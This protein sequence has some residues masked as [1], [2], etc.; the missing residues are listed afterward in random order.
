MIKKISFIL[1][2][3]ISSFSIVLADE[4]DFDFV[5]GFS[6]IVTDEY[7]KNFDKNISKIN[8]Q[9]QA[10]GK[11][12]FNINYCYVSFENR[13]VCN[14]L[15]DLSNPII[16]FSGLGTHYI[17]FNSNF[18]SPFLN[19]NVPRYSGYYQYFALTMVHLISSRGIMPFFIAPDLVYDGDVDFSINDDIYNSIDEK[20][21]KY[22]DFKNYLVKGNK[23]LTYLDLVYGDTYKTYSVNLQFCYEDN[24][25]F[26]DYIVYYNVFDDSKTI[27][28]NDYIYSGTI[29]NNLYK[30]DL[31]VDHNIAVGSSDV[32]KV[33]LLKKS[34]N[35]GYYIYLDDVFEKY[36]TISLFYGDEI[37]LDNLKLPNVYK[38]VY[39]FDSFVSYNSSDCKDGFVVGDKCKSVNVYYKSIDVNYD[40]NV[41]LDDIYYKSYSYVGT[42]KVGQEVI[43]EDLDSTID[44]YTLD[45]KE[46]KL[47]LVD[48]RELN[49]INVYYYSANYGTK[50]QDI[51]TSDKFYI[52]FDWLYIKDLFKLNGN[53]TQTE[54][55]VIVYVVNFLFYGIIA[56]IGYFAI[57]L[58]NKLFS[59]F[60]YL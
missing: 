8:I 5:S 56:L 21:K 15:P 59:I 27:N 19:F 39:Y 60:S 35:V 34:T 52:A 24:C 14:Y 13:V 53:Y 48:N 43:L 9:G 12:D 49:S 6:D 22:Y 38:D 46:Y 42:G 17:Y 26:G 18:Y 45:E 23:I 11:V 44:V 51:D 16:D 32:V 4:I 3:I 37:N 47:K 36:D 2:C 20:Y 33:N 55:F 7:M 31:S 50:Y 54:Q 1:I 28:I 30:P 57:K 58:L 40:V 25:D 10:E 29:F 41:Y